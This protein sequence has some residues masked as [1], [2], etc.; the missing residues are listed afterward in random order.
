MDLKDYSPQ[1]NTLLN[2]ITELAEEE[3]QNKKR[4]KNDALVILVDS[5]K[6]ARSLYPN[7]K[8]NKDGNFLDKLLFCADI[9]NSVAQ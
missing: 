5:A 8:G 4:A 6:E 2:K 1:L 7:H 9:F 3:A